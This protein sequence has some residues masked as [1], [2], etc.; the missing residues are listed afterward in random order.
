MPYITWCL[1]KSCVLCRPPTWKVTSKM[2][3]AQMVDAFSLTPMQEEGPIYGGEDE[4]C[5]GDFGYLGW[6]D[7]LR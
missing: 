3:G 2:V 5:V 7:H 6:L 1:G 4:L